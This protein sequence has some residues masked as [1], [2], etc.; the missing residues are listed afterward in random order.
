MLRTLWTSKAGMNANQERLD[1]IS[2]NISNVNTTG[3]KKVE[4]GF[5][6]LLSESLDILGTPLNAKDSVIGTGV[7]T[8]EW[9]RS[10]IQGSLIQT[11]IS[12][13][14]AIDGEG[15]FRITS[16]DGEA[17]YTRNGSFKLD[18]EGKLVDS[19]G[20]RLY[21][22]YVNG[23][24][25]NNLKLSTNNLLINNLGE[26]FV[27]ENGNSVKVAEI[28]LYVGIG[29]NALVSVGNSLYSQSNEGTMYRTTDNN[30][31]QGYIENSNVDI[32]EEFSDMIITQRAFQL[33]SKGIT[34]A[35]EM[36][37]MV[38]NLRR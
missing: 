14:I 36:W 26:V 2:N 10:N 18:A 15:Y 5:K 7:K 31:Y 37:G 3:Y 28:P 20:N 1:V 8:S 9:F 32:A 30:L 12:T 25:E 23:Y 21:L 16:A 11:A 35:D 17:L 22:H 38:N 34:V 24:S 4:V 27:R 13:D 6:D 29:D 19:N 33:S